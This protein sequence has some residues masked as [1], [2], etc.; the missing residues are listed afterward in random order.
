[1]SATPRAFAISITPFAET[2]ELDEA[3]FRAHLRRL[4]AA[5]I[6]IYVGGAGS[7]EGYTL[8]RDE[9][10]KLL[11]IAVDEV[12]GTVPIRAMGVEPRTADQMVDF[13]KLAEACGVDAAQVYS[14]DVGHGHAPRPDELKAYYGEV[15]GAV[16]M[17]LAFST[18]QSVGYV[19]PPE[20]IFALF[21]EHDN[22]IDLNCSH[23]DISYLTSLIEGLKG[24]ANIFVGGPHQATLCLSLGGYGFLTSEAN[25]APNLCMTVVNC[26]EAG[27]MHGM[28]NAY[29]KVIRLFTTT[30]ANG[31]IRAAKAVLNAHGVAGGWPRR[32]RLPIEDDALQAVLKVIR[33]EKIDAIENW[34]EWQ[35]KD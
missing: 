17:P 28:F 23:Q 20:V 30:Y 3:R 1:M 19:I 27:D 26:Y 16:S 18:H 14:L 8:S 7:G 13:L 24:R 9:T 25:I 5:G 31:G 15:L 29:G 32:P 4:A 10:R 22:L 35:F 11:E 2:G 34:H 6:G 33:D 12:K 21:K